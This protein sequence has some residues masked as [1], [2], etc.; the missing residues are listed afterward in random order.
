MVFEAFSCLNGFIII[1]FFWAFLSNRKVCANC[2]CPRENHDVS[3]EVE[4]DGVEVQV[5]GLNINQDTNNKDDLPSPPPLKSSSF[6][7]P[8]VDIAI[9]IV[10]DVLPPPP[11]SSLASDYI[12]SPAG[13]TVGQVK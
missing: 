13:L 11:P 2:K 6:E 7:Y 1:F 12:W 5:R 9:P 3:V 10:K 8:T 4:L